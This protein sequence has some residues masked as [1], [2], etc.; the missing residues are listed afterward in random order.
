[1]V[2][3]EVNKIAG[4]NVQVNWITTSEVNVSGYDVEA[5]VNGG[6]FIKI[7]YVS[8][9]ENDYPTRYTFQD[10]QLNKSGV[11]FYRL[12]MID[13]DGS[14]TYSYVRSL[15]FSSIRVGLVNIFPNPAGNKITISVNA[16]SPENVSVIIA[17]MDGQKVLEKTWRVNK[18]IN[19]LDQDIHN[20]SKSMYL[21]SIKNMSNGEVTRQNFQ[22]L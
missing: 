4:D 5:S 11:R 16:E 13:K 12:K 8:A 14:F 21:L 9:K 17:N 2:N 20:L 19:T 3:F 7:G 1:L 18:G 22:K 10:L 6:P 15:Q